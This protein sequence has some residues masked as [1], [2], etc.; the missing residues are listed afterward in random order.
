MKHKKPVSKITM[1]NAEAAESGR[2]EKSNDRRVE[3][4]T[5]TDAQIK[6][7]I[8]QSI[9]EGELVNVLSHSAAVQSV[10]LDE[11]L[12][13]LPQVG[14][15]RKFTGEKP[16]PRK[17]RE[18]AFRDMKSAL[19]LKHSLSDQLACVEAFLNEEKRIAFNCSGRER[20]ALL[21]AVEPSRRSLEIKVQKKNLAEKL[22]PAVPPSSFAI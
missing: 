22:N 10:E 12:V 18:E 14:L 19:A 9:R 5:V 4:K 20:S 21:D 7:S 11:P 6:L 15:E 1:V 16:Y 3:E 2:V 13:S 8:F 17:E